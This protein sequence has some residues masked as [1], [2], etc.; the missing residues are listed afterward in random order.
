MPKAKAKRGRPAYAVNDRDRGMV[1]AHI[2]CGTP[3][4]EIA[5]V[6]RID[7]KTLRKYYA[8]EIATSR[9]SANA[10][11]AG[12]LF[13]MALGKDGQKP[14]VIAC[15]FW[16]KTRARWREL[17]EQPTPEFDYARLSPE[18]RRMLKELLV[19]AQIHPGERKTEEPAPAAA[20]PPSV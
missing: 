9:S 18:R 5:R 20:E 8:H 19:E 11:V 10:A 6:L 15:I 14:N 16:L 7:P 2:A 3:E 13:K 1:E 12:S 17:D 4:P